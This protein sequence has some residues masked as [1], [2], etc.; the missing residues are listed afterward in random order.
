MLK[1]LGERVQPIYDTIPDAVAKSKT[2]VC[3]DETGA[4]VN[5]KKFWAWI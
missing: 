2:A 4:K 3:G 5:G 1:R